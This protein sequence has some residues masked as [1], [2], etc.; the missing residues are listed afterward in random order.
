MSITVDAAGTF[1][2]TTSGT[3]TGVCAVSG[4][5]IQTSP[6]TSKNMYDFRL[7]AADAAKS[8]EP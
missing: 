4:D 6:G 3:A 5:I 1:G 7:K 2:G 8:G